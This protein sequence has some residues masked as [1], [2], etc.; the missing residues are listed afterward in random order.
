MAVRFLVVKDILKQHLHRRFAKSKLTGLECIVIDEINVRKGHKY[1]TLVMDLRS[2]KVVFVGDGQVGE[3][4]T[5]EGHP[6]PAIAMEPDD[7]RLVNARLQALKGRIFRKV[8]AQGALW[9]HVHPWVGMDL[10]L[11]SCLG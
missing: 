11:H 10:H 6:C 7:A 5:G 2:G 8:H 1:L 3:S 4:V 9:Q